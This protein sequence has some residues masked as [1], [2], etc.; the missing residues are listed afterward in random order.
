MGFEKLKS[1]AVK[2]F[3]DAR[4]DDFG[5]YAILKYP[6]HLSLMKMKVARY[7]VSGFGSI[8]VM[9]TSM[10]GMRNSTR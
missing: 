3:P 10:M 1:E 5:D 9:N 7:D 6:K 4:A 8:M 2:L